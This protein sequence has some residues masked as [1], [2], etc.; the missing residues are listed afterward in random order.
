MKKQDYSSTTEYQEGYT[1]GEATAGTWRIAKRTSLW[2][3]GTR[4][5][6]RNDAIRRDLRFRGIPEKSTEGQAFSQGFIA[7]YTRAFARTCGH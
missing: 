2:K 7:A 4:T 1:K 6:F 5:E 3:R